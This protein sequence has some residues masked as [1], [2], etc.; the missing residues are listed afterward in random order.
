MVFLGLDE[1]EKMLQSHREW[2]KSN[3][4]EGNRAVFTGRV[5]HKCDHALTG[6]CLDQ[7]S[8]ICADL[9]DLT[10]SNTRFRQSMLRNSQLSAISAENA[11]FT[12]SNLVGSEMTSM[13][14]PG[15]IFRGADLR[16]VCLAASICRDSDFTGAD[17][18]GAM[19]CGCDFTSAD[20]TG[21]DLRG[22]DYLGKL[23]IVSDYIDPD[24]RILNAATFTGAIF[25]GTLMDE[26]LRAYLH[27]FGIA[28][29]DHIV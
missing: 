25:K 18:R 11:D 8:G 6:R 26:G 28:T 27:K 21:A 1:L 16:A 5:L 14:A 15:C 24:G 19:L 9:S 4:K 10:L 29:D 3:H 7:I 22:V 13:Y 17:L 23:G 2:L 12:Q 20:F